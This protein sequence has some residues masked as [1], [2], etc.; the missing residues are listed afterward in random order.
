M[1]EK[2]EVYLCTGCGIGDAL[3]TE[4]LCN[5]AKEEF[6]IE[7]K[8]DAFLCSPKGVASMKKD[9]EQDGVDTIVIA[10]CSSRV[11]WDVFSFEPLIVERVNLRE[12]VVWS[13]TPNDEDTQMLAEDCL[14]MG[15]VRAQKTQPLEPYLDSVEKVI[16]VVGGG[17][18]GITS[19]LGAANAGYDVVLVEK[20]AALGG[21]LAKF[22]KLSPKHP[23]YRDLEEPDIE[24][25]IKDVVGN[26][27]VKVLTSAQIEK[28]SG[29][30]GSFNATI[31]Q[32]GNAVDIKIGSIVL[33]TGWQPYDATKLDNLGFG[34]CQNVITSV[35]M[36]EIAKDGKI[37]RPSDGKEVNSVAFIQ[38][39][40][41]RD[42][43]HLPY[44]SSVCCLVSLKQAIYIRERNPDANVYIFYK[45]IRTPAQ[46]EDFYRRVQEDEGVFFTKGEVTSVTE[47][48]EG[49][50]VIDVEHTL[51]GERIRV[52]AD[53]VVLAIGM[54]PA[55]MPEVE[56]RA[57]V[58]AGSTPAE[59]EEAV[60][61]APDSG[62]YAAPILHLEYRQGPELPTLKY[63][64]PDS[65]YICF[66]YESR[67][68]AVYAAGC[69]RQPMDVTAS[70]EDAGGAALKAIQSLELISRGAALHPR[71]GDLSYPDFSLLRCTQCK[72]CTI[73]CPF[74]ALEEDE[75][76]TPQPNPNRCRRCGICFGCCPERLISFKNYSIDQL[77]SM[78]KIIH[79][80]EDEDK[81]RVLVLCCEND[82]YPAFDIAGINRLIYDP[83]IR[84][85][86]LR[87]L[88][89][90]H[91][92]LINDA[93]ARG[94]DG[95]ILMGC[96]FGDDY[97]CHFIKGSE[98][99]N[100]R[101]ENIQ[102]VLTR[103]VLETQRVKFVDLPI[104]DYARIPEIVN[105]FMAEIKKIGPN[106]FKGL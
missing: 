60:E 61:H 36:E 99:A 69:T 50:V 53:M 54:V 23:P 57:I 92:T 65:N 33:A 85:L 79:I 17:I 76:G 87:C 18:T 35:M 82:A 56:D 15:I 70:V 47:D 94:I 98:L 29:Q 67:R 4:K 12:Q 93:V 27:K 42:E 32:D 43:K 31:R 13:H 5:I 81:F 9:I 28:I 103:L 24:A 59:G 52:K 77:T 97:Q 100:T 58:E 72:R 73:E 83:S 75:K 80:P 66:P 88:G 89:S 46:Y 26:P 25:K 102:E 62:F 39:A 45:D 55:T 49:S 51:L 14:R 101:M 19:A 21:W 3:D 86:P 68:T 71:V 95:I 90:M 105:E 106:P 44:C 37:V 48:G 10:A 104:T 78:I 30:P 91:V 41:S 20:E 64:F 63:G 6:N 22:S 7:A 40:G 84:I 2:V 11:N 1:A 16:L 38:C 8:T 74:G 34:K 96:K